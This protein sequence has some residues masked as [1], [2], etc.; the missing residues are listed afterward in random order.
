[1]HSTIGKGLRIRTKKREFTKL[2]SFNP[3]WCNFLKL[4]PIAVCFP[5]PS[6]TYRN[7]TLA[8]GRGRISALR[9]S[10]AESDGEETP[11]GTDT[12]SI[13][14]GRGAE[15]SGISLSLSLSPGNTSW[16]Q[17]SAKWTWHIG[18]IHQKKTKKAPF[19][20]WHLVTH[21]STG[22][23]V[24]MQ[25]QG[26]E[27]ARFC[28]CP[29]SNSIIA[30]SWLL[31]GGQLLTSFTVKHCYTLKTVVFYTLLMPWILD[32][33]LDHFLLSFITIMPLLP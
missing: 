29:P 9:G 15:K 25:Y 13:A 3:S 1:M 31:K 12:V 20:K 11:V 30:I 4:I 16:P 6:S 5:K 23:F 22:G 26:E 17:G 10:Q 18:L 27:I 32:L 24:S 8:S 21:N 7:G 14:I 28:L 2:E 33:S 19:Q